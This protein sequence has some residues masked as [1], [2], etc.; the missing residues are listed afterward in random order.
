MSF[1]PIGDA[2]LAALAPALVNVSILRLSGCDLTRQSAASLAALIRD[3]RALE[4]LHAGA[5]QL[6]AF[7]FTVIATALQ[8]SS[9]L[10]TLHLLVNLSGSVSAD[11][12]TALADAL[13]RG[14]RASELYLDSDYAIGGGGAVALAAA[15][16]Q[17]GSRCTLATLA[18]THCG[19]TAAGALA[20]VHAAAVTPRLRCLELRFNKAITVAD[21]P[22]LIAACGPQPHFELRLS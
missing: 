15:L 5:N 20:L 3:S 10:R 16:E 12:A 17:L 22:A 21:R 13:R 9:S 7:G 8:P 11:G 6:G 1:N 14:W 19:I 18:L 2:G 4:S